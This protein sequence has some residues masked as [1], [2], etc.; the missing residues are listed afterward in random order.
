MKAAILSL[1]LT[2]TFVSMANANINSEMLANA[3][4]VEKV[5]TTLENVSIL[6]V[7]IE[8]DKDGRTGFDFSLVVCGVKQSASGLELVRTKI[9]GALAF[10]PESDKGKVSQI[11]KVLDP[12]E[13]EKEP[14]CDSM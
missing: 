13:M 8:N 11:T 1:A 6:S 9:D 12:R 2:L 3:L 14:S 10:F 5:K 7:K 4:K